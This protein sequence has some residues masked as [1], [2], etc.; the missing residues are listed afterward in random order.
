[1]E[2][3]RSDR[4]PFPC[5]VSRRGTPLLHWWDRRPCVIINDPTTPRRVVGSS[6][7]GRPMFIF[8][9]S[10]LMSI[11]ALVFDFNGVILDD[12][13]VHGE[14]FRQVLA[15]L[16]V[17]I[18]EED[19]FRV[20]LGFDD[21]LCLETALA[22]HGQPAPA[23]LID[24]L[25]ER[26]AALYLQRAEAGLPFYDQASE[27]VGRLCRRYPSAICSGALR[28]EIELA[29]KRLGVLDQVRSIVAAED[30]TQSKPDPEG[31]RLA[32][33]QLANQ[34][35][36]CDHPLQP[37]EVL[38]IE[39]TAMGVRS[40]RGAGLQVVGVATTTDPQAL[41][42]AGAFEVISRLADYD[43]DWITSRFG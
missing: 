30:V 6:A 27:V 20:Y 29:L 36:F 40:A 4:F 2:G 12:E 39:D 37:D 17:T 34:P 19:Y 9:E 3:H 42:E 5:R 25:V 22:N 24:Q 14:L 26:K 21:R 31:Y 8:S 43:E 7:L 11:R 28:P 41:L 18:S 38:V 16:G 15:P 13:I 10:F 35:E 23:E 33:R 1:M 32:F